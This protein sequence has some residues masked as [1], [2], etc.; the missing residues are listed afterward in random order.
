MRAKIEHF[1]EHE[2]ESRPGRRGAEKPDK[3]ERSDRAE[4]RRR[5]RSR[6][7]EDDDTAALGGD[8]D[9]EDLRAQPTLGFA[10]VVQRAIN[11]VVGAG[12]SEATG[13][14]V[15]VAMFS[16]RESHAVHFLQEEGIS[17][18]DVVSYLSHGISKLLPAK[19]PSAPSGIPPAGDDEGGSETA[20]DPL[21]AYAV[22]LNERARAG[23][24]D[25]L[26]GRQV[27]IER[28]L[29]VLAR[30]R[31]NSPLLVG[32]AG[33]GKTAIVEGLARRIEL[34]E[35]PK[36]LEGTTIYALDMGALVA[37]TRYRGDFEERFKAVL[38]AL[39]EKE[40]AVV[41]ID[42]MHT[43]V[44]AGAASGG[45]MDAS[46]LLKPLLS[47]GR[48][49]CIGTTT[50][51]EFR[52]HIEKDRAL[53]RR[54]QPIEVAELSIADTIKVLRGLQPKYEEFHKVKY[55]NK[56]L[57]AAAELGERY[58]ADRK[59]PDK[60][61]DLIDEAGAILKLKTDKQPRTVRARDIEAVVATMA[62]I[63]PRRVESDD[64]E[65]LKNLDTELKHRIFGQ[66]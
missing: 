43:I 13:P 46:N 1:L 49:R 63:P 16:E 2:M 59:L 8:D 4:H 11:H 22:N 62:R 29:H 17:R 48:L 37:G 55:T 52:G 20:A 66:D 53:A 45:A 27:E 35:A 56:S 33:V 7:R 31:K 32:D 3:V 65:R 60:A 6:D 58:L 39:E 30:R 44:G 26:I 64:R 10:R 15:L 42:E 25:P 47:A 9:G 38:K 36:A 18:L 5:V 51:K 57:R 41:F 40:K 12:R 24:I 28:A 14:N 19:Q 23:E 21:T 61:I 54:F 34:G 50:H